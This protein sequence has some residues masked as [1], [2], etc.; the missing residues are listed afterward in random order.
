MEPR[1]LPEKKPGD[2]L[3]AA[4]VN[5]LSEAAKRM[6]VVLPGAGQAGMKMGGSYHISN[7]PAVP[8]E[9]FRITQSLG[10]SL[11]KGHR[12]WYS[13]EDEEWKPS[14]NDWLAGNIN[15]TTNKEWTIDATGINISLAI[16]S[17][18]N[19]S[20]NKQRSA[21]V[22]VMTN[23]REFVLGSLLES[24]QS[25]GSALAIAYTDYVEGYG[26]VAGSYADQ[27]RVY[28]FF[29]RNSTI[30]LSVYSDILAMFY[31]PFNRYVLVNAGNF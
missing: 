16:G 6:G 23:F 12:L 24:L 18:V 4:H 10:D 31:L 9:T 28:D 17:Y 22:P 11:Y 27:F 19:V 7:I 26:P 3:E 21:Y 5:V 13:Q 1:D 14:L 15:D 20:Y 25:G 8:N 2:F 29:H 30:H